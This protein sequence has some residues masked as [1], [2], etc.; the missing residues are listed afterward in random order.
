MR[1]FPLLLT[2]LFFAN[3]A[4]AIT[5][6]APIESSENRHEVMIVGSGGTFCTGA[7][8][9]RDV[10]LTAAHCVMPRS[11]YKVI[12]FNP[13]REPYFI[14]VRTVVRHP[15]FSLSDLLGHRATAD[16]A[17]LKMAAPLPQSVSPAVMGEGPA[18][19]PGDEYTIRGYGVAVRGDGK[20]GGTLRSARLAATGKPGNLQVRLVDATT[21]GI[22]AGLGACTGDSGAPVYREAVLVGVV[23]WSTA[24]KLEQG[25]GG[26][27][28]VTP[29]A[30]Y[31]SWIV[32]TASKLRTA[33]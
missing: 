1:W 20:T 10:V 11:D 32:T 29:L 28:G 15:K 14:D 19:K 5:G 8:I 2:T 31:L 33:P 12:E 16:V 21:G 3:P 13:V 17:L 25:C 30:L 9:A 22:K 4:L 26:L 23:S 7:A 27:T 18:P 24:P 6:S